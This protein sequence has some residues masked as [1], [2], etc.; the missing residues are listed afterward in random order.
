M[1]FEHDTAAAQ[2]SVFEVRERTVPQ[3]S[4][5]W[6]FMFFLVLVLE[7]RSMENVGEDHGEDQKTLHP[8]LEPVPSKGVASLSVWRWLGLTQG[9]N[10][11]GGLSR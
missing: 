8:L 2:K 4:I 11:G 6:D 1:A 10:L 5:E 9:A 3:A 7:W